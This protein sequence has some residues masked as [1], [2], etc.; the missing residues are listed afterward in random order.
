MSE[1]TYSRAQRPRRD[2]SVKVSLLERRRTQE[3][4]MDPNLIAVAVVV[5]A[6]AVIVVTVAV[7]A[8]RAR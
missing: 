7:V 8:T 6:I 4:V 5:V 1:E 2:Q 3:K